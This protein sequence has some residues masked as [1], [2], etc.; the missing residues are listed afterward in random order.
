MMDSPDDEFG[1]PAGDALVSPAPAQ[2][3][4]QTPAPA[5]Q[6]APQAPQAAPAAAPPLSPR[7]EANPLLAGAPKPG[8]FVK[9]PSAG[10]FYVHPPHMVNGEVSVLPMTADCEIQLQNPDGLLNDESIVHVIREC[11]PGIADPSEVPIPDLDVLMLGLHVATYGE[12]MEVEFECAECGNKEAMVKNLAVVIAGVQTIPESPS[13]DVQGKR[14]FLR[15]H[16]IA[17][18]RRIADFVLAAQRAAFLV[19]KKHERLEKEIE[20]ADGDRA[21]EDVEALRAMQEEV[22]G[23]VRTM[24]RKVFATLGD[25]VSAVENAPGETVTNRAH[26]DEWL[27][28]LRAPDARK[29]ADAVKDLENSVPKTEECKCPKCGAIGELGVETNPANFSEAKSS[30][31]SMTAKSPN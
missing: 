9:L 26:I 18:R 28:S 6:A 14:V 15:P 5:P 3:A 11:V 19:G 13:V 22:A 29:I 17:S 4:P 30:G 7:P 10:Q 8:T 23:H 1:M 12:E 27:S 25:T 31:P 21:E 16:T 20:E 2:E 24:S